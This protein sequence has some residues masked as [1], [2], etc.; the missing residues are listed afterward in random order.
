MLSQKTGLR[1]GTDQQEICSAHLNLRQPPALSSV[2][3]SATI[4][5]DEQNW[6][7]LTKSYVHTLRAIKYKY[8]K[9]KVKIK[10][11][12]AQ[13]ILLQNL[14]PL[15]TNSHQNKHRNFPIPQQELQNSDNR[16]E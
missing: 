12:R 9:V 1:K 11:P 15:T 6:I 5:M 14:I 16:D 3:V 4:K 8:I 13:I 10:T 2:V 7:I